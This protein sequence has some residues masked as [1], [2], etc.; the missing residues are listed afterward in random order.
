MTQPDASRA[1]AAP[2]AMTVDLEVIIDPRVELML[3]VQY[4]TGDYERRTNLITNSTSNTSARSRRTFDRSPNIPSS[5]RFGKWHG[6]AFRSMPAPRR[7]CISR[8]TPS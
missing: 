1:P 2:P 8:L 5:R 7:R 3:I 4:L 6:R